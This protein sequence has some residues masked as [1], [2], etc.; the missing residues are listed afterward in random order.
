MNQI[1][2][3][4]EPEELMAYLDGELTADHASATAAHLGECA[5]CQNLVAELRSVSENLQP[6]KVEPPESEMS[7]AIV[8][9]LAEKQ[10]E[11]RKTTPLSRLTWREVLSKRWPTLAWAGTAAAALVLLVFSTV[12]FRGTKQFDTLEQFARLQNAPPPASSTVNPQGS[13]QGSGMSSGLVAATPR[14]Q[15]SRTSSLSANAWSASEQ[16]DKGEDTESAS[17]ASTVPP[18][19]GPMIIR[20]AQLSLITKE[21]DKA[22]TS[23]EAILKQHRGFVGE[24]KVGGNTGS[25]RTLTATLRVPADQLDGMLADTKKLGRVDSE[26]QG[27]QD[28]TSEYIDLQARLSNAHNTA[29]RL[30]EI[31][32]NRTGKLADVLAVEQALDRV[33]GEIEQMEAERKTMLNQVSYATLTATI[34]EDYQAQLQAVP[35]STSTRLGNAAVEGYRNMVEGILSLA[36]F[37]LSNG[38]SLLLWGAILFMPARTIWK[39][40][41]SSFAS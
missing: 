36:L 30:T 37:L 11:A 34:T 14:P 40:L 5:E 15:E 26:T 9:A 10:P 24:L 13:G 23:L 18:V 8:T 21:F 19:Q 41:R 17:P 25:G 20:T 31:L 2:H 39:K 12:T 35:P 6:W 38:P 22:R 3:P 7:S 27:G 1:L 28:T 4:I 32:R 33:R 16:E 29:Q